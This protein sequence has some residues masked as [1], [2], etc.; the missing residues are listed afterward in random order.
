MVCDMNIKDP[1]KPICS[2]VILD[3]KR[4]YRK[5]IYFRFRVIIYDFNT[6][7]QIWYEKIN[8]NE[9]FMD[10][11]VFE[12]YDNKDKYIEIHLRNHNFSVPNSCMI[13]TGFN[14]LWKYYTGDIDELKF[15]RKIEFGNIDILCSDLEINFESYLKNKKGC[16][17]KFTRQ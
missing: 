6:T 10:K 5:I 8:E 16:N 14:G 2:M 3:R 13:K 7:K 9:Y 11:I 1:Y 12:N 15:Y 17:E 4:A